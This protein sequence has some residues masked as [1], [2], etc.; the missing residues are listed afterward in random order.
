[1]RKFFRTFFVLLL[2]LVAGFAAYALI[3]GKTYLF[4]AVYYNFAGIDDYKIFT[5]DTV[6]V[7]GPQPWLVDAG[8][9]VTMPDSLASLL[10][11]LN[12]VAVLVIR[13]GKIVFEKYDDGY[14]DSS[15]SNSFSMAK[16]ITSLLVGAAIREGLIRSVNDRVGNYL[17]E[18]STGLAAGLKIRDLLTMSSGSNW[19][20]SYA[21]PLSVTT[22]AY[23][24]SD[25]RSTA[26]SVSI[27]KTPGTYFSYKSGDTELLGL[28]VEKA[29]G[30][31]LANYAAE[32]L[33]RP[34][35]AEHP[36][37]WST[38]RAG[39]SAKAYCCF[40]TNARDFARIGQLMLDS[41]KW[42]GTPIIDSNYFSES[43]SPC[44]VPDESGQPT[45]YY[46]YQWWIRPAYPGVFY[47]RGILGQYIIM[48]PSR[49]MVM[50]RLGHKRSSRRVN[51]APEEVDALINWG[52][53]L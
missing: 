5:N 18:F 32:K 34:I 2:L 20:E 48:I 53:G 36:A 35:G 47:A 39:G 12:T 24:G 22:E 29:T 6:H 9:T 11:G 31:S 16:S 19:D 21:N 50:V 7:A 41:G 49:K 23:Y 30:R 45:T 14:S 40:N 3:T 52:M 17:P 1:M 46:G 4:K 13:D 8:S 37:L 27:K 25:L 44:L 33:W 26:T 42:K 51:D 15:L 43:V 28:I 38:D 10:A